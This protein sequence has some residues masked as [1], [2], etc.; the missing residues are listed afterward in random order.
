MN[1]YGRDCNITWRPREL[2]VVATE[3]RRAV[4][5]HTRCAARVW[6]R[7]SAAP[8]H[9]CACCVAFCQRMAFHASL[10]HGGGVRVACRVEGSVLARPYARMHSPLAAACG[11]LPRAFIASPRLHTPRYTA[12]RVIVDAR[13]L[14]RMRQS[15]LSALRAMRRVF[16]AS[17]VAEVASRVVYADPSSSPRFIRQRGATVP[18]CVFQE[19]AINSDKRYTRQRSDRRLR[20]R[21]LRR[22]TPLTIAVEV[23]A[24]GCVPCCRRRRRYRRLHI[25]HASV[26]VRLRIRHDAVTRYVRSDI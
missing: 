15:A 13:V 18:I 17:Y 8:L 26:T 7:T 12:C 25:R 5:R 14:K 22:R 19:V 3:L 1:R 11:R 24:E 4:S 23:A 9:T 6:F 21:M 10:R 16:V 2:P 20:E